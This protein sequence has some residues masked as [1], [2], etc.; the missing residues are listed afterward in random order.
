MRLAARILAVVILGVLLGLLATWITVFRGAM[1]DRVADGPWKTNLA[2]GDPQSGPYTR[3]AIALHGLFALNRKEALYYNAARDSDG[4]RLDSACIY[5]I[6]G[7]DPD[8]RWWSI[9]AYGADDF[10]ISNPAGLY[11]VSETTVVRDPNGSF[12][13]EV[14]GSSKAK[15]WIPSGTGRF[16][17]TLRLYNPGPDIALDPARATLPVLKK[18]SCS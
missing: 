10:L 5:R 16:S 1:L 6:A 18:V 8:A 17:L 13:I 11:S 4:N 2:A 9:T 7:H 3:A 15:N 14:G 12:V